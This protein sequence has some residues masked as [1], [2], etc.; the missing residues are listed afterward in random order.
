MSLHIP[1]YCSSRVMFLDVAQ[2]EINFLS[3]RQ[4][5]GPLRNVCRFGNVDV[6]TDVVKL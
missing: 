2:E 4:N 5:S 1:G 3:I 6:V